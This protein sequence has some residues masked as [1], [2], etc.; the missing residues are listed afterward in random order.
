MPI[1]FDIWF[2]KYGNVLAS[3]GLVLHYELH[4]P[5]KRPFQVYVTINNVDE[6]PTR[7]SN[8]AVPLSFPVSELTAGKAV[9]TF[10]TE[11]GDTA[12]DYEK[13]QSAQKFLRSLT[14]TPDDGLLT[15][16]PSEINKVWSGVVKV[17]RD[18]QLEDVPDS[19]VKVYNLNA[20]N[21]SCYTLTFSFSKDGTRVEVQHIAPDKNN[22]TTTTTT[23]A[24]GSVSDPNPTSTI[25]TDD[26]DEANITTPHHDNATHVPIVKGDS[27]F[28]SFGPFSGKSQMQ[29]AM[30]TG[31]IAMMV[32]AA[33][34]CLVLVVARRRRKA[35][36]KEELEMR[37]HWLEMEMQRQ[38][39][40][41]NKQRQLQVLQQIMATPADLEPP[42]NAESSVDSITGPEISGDSDGSVSGSS[43][44]FVFHDVGLTGVPLEGSMDAVHEPH[45]A[46]PLQEPP[47]SQAFP[48]FDM[49]WVHPEESVDRHAYPEPQQYP[50]YPYPEPQQYPEHNPEPQQYPNYPYPEQQQYPEHNPEPQQYMEHNPEPQQYMEHDPNQQ[51]YYM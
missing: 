31:G 32:L 4:C 45:A 46:I 33:G 23:L 34:L 50:N 21:I 44:S 25:D 41:M 37:Q 36:E 30:V 20:T 51:D 10:N 43:S 22:T 47:S 2:S 7:C 18:W 19:R 24:H 3:S 29:T 26:S 15:Y 35:M 48:Y 27:E 1:D 38:E 5:D 42:S 11:D 16:E 14:L 40:E 8:K 6:F 13:S 12:D 39:E 28:D 9:L 49:N 17:K